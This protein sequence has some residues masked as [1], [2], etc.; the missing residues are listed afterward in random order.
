MADALEKMKEFNDATVYSLPAG[1][2]FD[3]ASVE[4]FFRNVT[5]LTDG[6]KYRFFMVEADGEGI[7]E[8]C[9][10][11]NVCFKAEYVSEEGYTY[12]YTVGCETVLRSIPAASP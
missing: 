11:V 6:S 10:C 3:Q 12:T 9:H 2:E 4:E 5:G 7:P 1:E 8:G